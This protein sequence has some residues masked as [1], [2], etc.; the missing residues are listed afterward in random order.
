MCQR[1]FFSDE[2]DLTRLWKTCIDPINEPDDAIWEEKI[3]WILVN[4]GYAV[5]K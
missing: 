3:T 1:A 4:A 5:R 2:E